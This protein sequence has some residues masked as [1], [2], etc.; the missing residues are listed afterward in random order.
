MR[1]NF[2][3]YTGY[4]Y[5]LYSDGLRNTRVIIVEKRDDINIY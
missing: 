4:F 5:T 2:L 1:Y 3:R